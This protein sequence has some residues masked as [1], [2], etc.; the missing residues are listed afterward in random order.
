MT[1]LPGQFREHGSASQSHPQAVG[2]GAYIGAGTACDPKAYKRQLDLEHVR[3]RNFHAF[4]LLGHFLALA[5]QLVE[6]LALV[7][8]RGIGGHFLLVQGQPV[9]HLGAHIGF[10]HLLPRGFR[11]HLALDVP[12]IGG[13]AQAQL[14]AVDLAAVGQKVRGDLGALSQQHQQHAG[15]HGVQGARV[16]DLA[17]AQA[18]ERREAA[19][20]RGA[21]RLVEHQDAVQLGQ[22]RRFACGGGSLFGHT[23]KIMI[24]SLR[25]EVKSAGIWRQAIACCGPK[26]KRFVGPRRA[27]GTANCPGR[28]SDA[29]RLAGLLRGYRI[30]P[31]GQPDARRILPRGRLPGPTESL[32]P[33]SALM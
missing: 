27:A 2:Q 33:P 11:Q 19:G 3:L 14:A 24:A 32:Y 5:R 28:L 10:G 21:G 1:V 15:S 18:L 12:G 23:Q 4:D 17:L 31:P 26:V 7:L 13:E 20:R 30:R 25:H 29:A 8:G 9:G 6:G 22:R 16:A